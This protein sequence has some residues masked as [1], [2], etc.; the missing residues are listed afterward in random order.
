LTRVWCNG[1]KYCS[2]P[3]LADKW[4]SS[5]EQSKQVQLSVLDQVKLTETT[6]YR[7]YKIK[8]FWAS[9]F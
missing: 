8:H 2:C 1:Q 3:V 4:L 7:N 5:Q 6:N 9:K